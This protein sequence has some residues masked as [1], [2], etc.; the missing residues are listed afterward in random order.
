MQAPPH[1]PHPTDDTAQIGM[2]TALLV[3]PGS[4]ASQGV[5]AKPPEASSVVVGCSAPL[6]RHGTYI[7]QGHSE[8]GE[9][10]RLR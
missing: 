9:V 8:V 6:L 4:P 2:N 3:I 7:S 1:I 5:Q 10:S